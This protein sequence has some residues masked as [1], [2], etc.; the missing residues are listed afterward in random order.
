MGRYTVG[1]AA[2]LH[3]GADDLMIGPDDQGLDAQ[4]VDEIAVIHR[5]DRVS[6]LGDGLH[7]STGG[8]DRGSI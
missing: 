6:G 7:R 3:P 8:R 1:I 5:H 4:Y 2:A